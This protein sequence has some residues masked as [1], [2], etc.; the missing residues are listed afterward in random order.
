MNTL[1][2]FLGIIVLLSIAY[3]LSNNR[4]AIRIRTV[5]GALIIQ[6]S[7]GAFILYVPIGRDMLLVMSNAVS[8]VISFGNIGVEFLFGGLATDSAFKAFGNE[9]FIF[10]IRVLPIIVFFSALIS[11]LYYIGIMQWIIKLI[12]G[13]LQKILATSKAESM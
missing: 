4:K 9:G 2:S 3:A 11:L 12:G 1:T 10:A 6:I 13:T 8:K 5:L 7:I